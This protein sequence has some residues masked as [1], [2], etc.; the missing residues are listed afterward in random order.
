MADVPRIKICGLTRPG[1]ARA[2]AE[3]G[4]D[5][6][7]VVTVPASPR[8]VVE[9]ERARAIRGDLEPPL[10]LVS[11]DRDPAELASDGRTAGAGV[12][13]LHG[14]ETPDDLRRLRDAG[15][16]TLWKAVRIR[17]P[18]DLP[19]AVDRFG[20]LADALLLDAWHPERL[21]GTGETFDWEAV[22]ALR[23]RVPA[24]VRLV[25]A[26]GL[27]PE[28]VGDAVRVLRP[29][30]VDVSSGVEASPGVKDSERVRAFVRAVRRSA[31]SGG[32]SSPSSR[33]NDETPKHPSNPD[34]SEVPQR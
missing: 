19:E 5:Y 3:A 24:G 14:S 22:R 8:A 6:L 33:T 4:A 25:A 20:G 32:G 34:T 23:G 18:D 16:W 10:V 11:A 15:S 30:V 9:P 13:Q 21:G 1:D 26:G 17:A 27:R 12:L 28:N 29:D 7:G 2:A 31:E